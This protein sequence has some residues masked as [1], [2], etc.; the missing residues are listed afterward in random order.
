MFCMDD[1]E[2]SWA[3]SR[4]RR[5]NDRLS[6]GS[7]IAIALRRNPLL[8]TASIARIRAIVLEPDTCP[9]RLSAVAF[10]LQIPTCL[11]RQSGSFPTLV[12][13]LRH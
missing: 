12:D 1:T 11:A 2:A 7:E 3:N 10:A 5:R 4:G 8:L 6:V 13:A 9:T